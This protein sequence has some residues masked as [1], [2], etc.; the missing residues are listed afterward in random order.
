MVCLSSDNVQREA[1]TSI[2]RNLP[3]RRNLRK[4]KRNLTCAQRITPFY[5][6]FPFKRCLQCSNRC[7]FSPP[8][9]IRALCIIFLNPKPHVQAPLSCVARVPFRRWKNDPTEIP[10]VSFIF[11]KQNGC[12]SRGGGKQKRCNFANGMGLLK[13]RA[14]IEV[15]L[16]R[17]SSAI[18]QSRHAIST[19]LYRG[20]ALLRPPYWGTPPLSDRYS[21][22]DTEVNR[23]P[24]KTR[25]TIEVAVFV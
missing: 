25:D 18:S 2:T 24:Y 9:S 1:S 5:A 19:A 16:L 10:S 8:F 15:A 7:P 6:F 11:P 17:V 20:T 12:S 4:Q 14:T 21:G 3:E 22:G 23:N 13:T